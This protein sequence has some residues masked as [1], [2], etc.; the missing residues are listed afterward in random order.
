M[1]EDK[2]ILEVDITDVEEVWIEPGGVRLLLSTDRKHD[3]ALRLP[4]TVLATLEE[5]LAG[6]REAPSGGSRP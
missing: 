1:S 2:P 3:L 4:P 5:K 6:A